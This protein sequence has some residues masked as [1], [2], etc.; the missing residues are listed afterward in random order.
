MH[1]S[2]GPNRRNPSGRGGNGRENKGAAARILRR[3]PNPLRLLDLRQ[4]AD[5]RQHGQRPT[6]E[7]PRRDTFSQSIPSLDFFTPLASMWFL[8]R[9]PSFSLTPCGVCA[10]CGH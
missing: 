2:P 3:N 6:P 7:A 9:F 5:G 10:A 4:A 8:P 1:R